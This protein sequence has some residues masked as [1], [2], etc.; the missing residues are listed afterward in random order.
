MQISRDPSLKGKGERSFAARFQIFQKILRKKMF[1]SF[2]QKALLLNAGLG[3]H[4]EQKFDQTM[5]QKNGADFK[6]V[7]H[8]GGIKIAQQARLEVRVD[9]HE[10]KP[11]E[12][13]L[14]LHKF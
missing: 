9:V 8:D 6:T 2:K 14:V 3:G 5:I 10:G 13:V 1:C 11:L 4:R 12:E 7:R